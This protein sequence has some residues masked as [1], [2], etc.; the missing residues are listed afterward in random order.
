MRCGNTTLT[1][2]EKVI[3]SITESKFTAGLYRVVS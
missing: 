3:T 2:I 1:G